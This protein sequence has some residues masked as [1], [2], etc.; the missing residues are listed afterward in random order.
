MVVVVAVAIDDD[1]EQSFAQVLPATNLFD[2]SCTAS[3]LLRRLNGDDLIAC[4]CASIARLLIS[5]DNEDEAK[6]FELT[7]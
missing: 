6:L 4:A 7:V 3:R 5:Y 1:D 2:W